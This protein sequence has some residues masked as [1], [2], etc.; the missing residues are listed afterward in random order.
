PSPCGRA[1]LERP[2]D[3]GPLGREPTPHGAGRA[4]ELRVAPAEGAR[5]RRPRHARRELPARHLPR[6]GGCDAIR[7]ALRRGARGRG[8]AAA[9][10]AFPAALPRRRT[11]TVL[12][13]DLVD[14]SSLVEGLDPEAAHVLLQRYFAAGRAALEGHGGVVEK[15]IG[16][17]VMAV[18]GVPVAHE[19]DA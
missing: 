8:G 13:A 17:A 12:F 3:R 16:D 9:R 10:R 6:A 19:D 18:F 5:C 4:A 15:F 7:A 11:V 2:A 1:D 14:S